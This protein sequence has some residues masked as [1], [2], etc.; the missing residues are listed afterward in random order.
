MQPDLRGPAQ[1]GDVSR[2]GGN[3]GLVQNHIQLGIFKFSVSDGGNITRHE[4]SD[5]SD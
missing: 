3:L 4:K 1:P 5:Q 2:I